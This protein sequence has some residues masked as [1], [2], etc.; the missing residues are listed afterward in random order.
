M[1]PPLSWDDLRVVLVVSRHR[2]LLAAASELGVA[3][4]TVSRR[5]KTL[6]ASLGVALIDRT[7]E[8]PVLTAAGDELVAVAIE[9]EQRLAEASARVVGRDAELRGTIRFSTLDLH[10]RRFGPAIAAFSRSVPGVDLQ[11]STDVSHLS[12]RR[13]EADV[14]L[15]ST[16]RPDEGLVGRRIGPMGY[17]VY[18]AA[19]LVAEVGADAPLDAY[20]WISWDPAIEAR[21]TRRWLTRSVPAARIAAT[22]DTPGSMLDLLRQGV[23]AAHF[24]VVDG[25]RDPDLVRIR[26]REPDWDLDLWLLVHPDLR[27]AARVRAFTDHLHEHLLDWRDRL[28]GTQLPVAAPL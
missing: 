19:S 4:T 2:T 22:A 28:A 15:R 16:N 5:L 11:I 23:G 18:A 12:L 6:E 26:D 21:M 24:V 20:P 14:A 8:G 3:H 27:S 10:L 1:T 25:E 9:V 13:R 7:P 17:A